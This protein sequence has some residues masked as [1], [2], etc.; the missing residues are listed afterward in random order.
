[1]K[2]LPANEADPRLPG[3]AR[4]ES[5]GKRVLDFIAMP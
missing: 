2:V 4:A 1:M 3:Y 5:V